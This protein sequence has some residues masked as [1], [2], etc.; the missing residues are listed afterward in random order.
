LKTLNNGE[1]LKDDKVWIKMVELRIGA[2]DGRISANNEKDKSESSPR[3]EIEP[4]TEIVAIIKHIV[5]DLI[6]SGSS[7]DRIIKIVRSSMLEGDI[8]EAKIQQEAAF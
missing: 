6:I 8:V 7:R 3:V 4:R 5:D 1:I 2:I